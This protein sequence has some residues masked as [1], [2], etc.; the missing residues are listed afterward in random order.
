MS[1][2][3][4]E[5]LLRENKELKR[6]LEEM[7]NIDN[8]RE[9]TVE[10]ISI[11]KEQIED[12]KAQL[13]DWQVN[14]T[15]FIAKNDG[16]GSIRYV[17]LKPDLI[18]NGVVQAAVKEW[19]DRYNKLL[20][21][22]VDNE[23]EIA[24]LKEKLEHERL[25]TELVKQGAENTYESIIMGKDNKINELKKKLSHVEEMSRKEAEYF[26]DKLALEAKKNYDDIVARIG[27]IESNIEDLQNS[28]NSEL[29]LVRKLVNKLKVP[30]AVKFLGKVFNKT[31]AIEH[32]DKKL[33]AMLMLLT[34]KFKMLRKG[35]EKV[36]RK[37]NEYATTYIDGTT[38]HIT[39]SSW[40]V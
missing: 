27:E 8:Y 40:L 6:D 26:K 13:K 36:G 5:V 18:D 9:R 34:E 12:L 10:T 29:T 37:A 22:K 30:T 20:N 28:F 17:Q 24:K 15:V 21:N 16:Y 11:L 38:W 2:K 39:D 7:K 33:G 35:I 3:L 25:N 31:E 14:N 19:K 23:R 4:S 32:V 1:A